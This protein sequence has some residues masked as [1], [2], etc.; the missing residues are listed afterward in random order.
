MTRLPP[1]RKSLLQAAGQLALLAMWVGMIPA[2]CAGLVLRYLVPSTGGG[3]A[4]LVAL[5]GTRFG[6]YFGVALFFVFSA[7]ARYWR[8]RIPGGRY[9]SALPAHMVSDEHEPERLAG[10][11]RDAALYEDL[12]VATA[13]RRLE[14][15]LGVQ[16]SGEVES[17]L[18]ELREALEAG[19]FVRASGAR[20]R[21]ESTA[22]PLL[23]SRQWR[24]TA[25]LVA[26]VAGAAGAMFVV[27]AFVLQ[28][29]QVLSTSMLP[30][31]EPDD[32]VA[33]NALAYSVAAR[34]LP[35]R[36]DVVV[37]DSSAV[38]LGARAP[39]VPPIFVKR[40]VGLPGDRIEMHGSTPVINGWVVPTCYA[41]DYAYLA[42][43]AAGLA[44]QKVGGKLVVEFLDDRAF[45]TIQG[46]GPS[47]SE[48]YVVRP[49]EVFVLGDNR[50]TSLDSR[51]YNA[52]HGGGVPLAAIRARAQW[53]LTGAHRNGDLDLQRFFRPLDK[54]QA[55][56]RL[57]GFDTQAL[58][59]G[60]ARC[61]QKRPME[62]TP[63]APADSLAT[64]SPPK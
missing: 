54:L 55:R 51:A 33:G 60:V 8:Y 25:G 18:A 48:A 24:Q 45:L 39:E 27:R 40:V 30:T 2:L 10:W 22:A 53:F 11:A 56:L 36:A 14:R 1:L 34:R 46:V 52:G 42:G 26:T 57:E 6:L 41:G 61:L 63:P 23:A 21:I 7:L 59:A 19:D 5:L 64:W 17:A 44:Y 58:Q 62:T 12:R 20:R 50:D 4:G 37:F 38:G 32:R 31:L 13:Q 49:G 15:I 9:A 35:R 3:L 29:Y 43:D 47:F 16:K 28:P